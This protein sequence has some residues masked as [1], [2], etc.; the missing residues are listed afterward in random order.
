MDCENND[1]ALGRLFPGP[2]DGAWAKIGDKINQCLWTSGIGHDYGMTRVY[3]MAAER[4]GYGTSTYKPYFHG[5]SPF[6]G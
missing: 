3:Q 1:V 2:R 4:A 5:Q 6:F